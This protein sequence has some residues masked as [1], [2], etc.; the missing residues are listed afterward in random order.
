VDQ[1]CMC[2]HWWGFM[3]DGLAVNWP[4]IGIVKGEWKCA[5]FVIALEWLVRKAPLLCLN[6]VKGSNYILEEV[7]VYETYKGGNSV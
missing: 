5:Y 7:I 3:E 4:A 1:G 2:L 6:V